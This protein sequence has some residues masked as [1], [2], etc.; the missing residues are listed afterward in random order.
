MHIGWL[1]IVRLGLVLAMASLPRAPL[2]HRR[3]HPAFGWG[4]A[5][6]IVMVPLRIAMSGTAAWTSFAG[7]LVG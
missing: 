3:L 1:G 7:W 2:R 4:G 6:V 5:F